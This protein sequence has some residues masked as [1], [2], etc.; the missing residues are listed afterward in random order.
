MALGHKSTKC[1]GGTFFS[2][3]FSFRYGKRKA[4]IQHCAIEAIAT[5]FVRFLG[6]W[7]GRGGKKPVER[8]RAQL[9]SVRLSDRCSFAACKRLKNRILS[10]ALFL[11]LFISFYIREY[12][13]CTAQKLEKKLGSSDKTPQFFFLTERP[14]AFDT[15]QIRHKNSQ[16]IK[17]RG[18]IRESTHTHTR[19][20]HL[21]PI[22]SSPPRISQLSQTSELISPQRP[23][24][25]G[26]ENL[27]PPLSEP[28][29]TLEGTQTAAK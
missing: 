3:S 10:H 11:F 6:G 21:I 13:S 26:R 5:A 27:A 2:F 1:G 25:R 9:F 8:G 29:Q 4:G 12:V 17:N 16:G 23:R 22:L 15:R 18:G 28:Q 7:V 24:R 19:L 20:S 14:C